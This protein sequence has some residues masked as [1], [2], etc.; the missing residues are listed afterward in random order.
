VQPVARA[1]VARQAGPCRL[2][3]DLS[4]L[5]LILAA[6][7]IVCNVCVCV[8]AFA[9]LCVCGCVCVRERERGL[10]EQLLELRQVSERE[11]EGE[12]ERDVLEQLLELG[13]MCVCV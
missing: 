8:F 4:A 9:C 6:P 2:R 12:R 11:R 10:L 13:P 1:A 3:Q 5:P 7:R